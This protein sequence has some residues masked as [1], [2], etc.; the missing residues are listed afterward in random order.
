MLKLFGVTTF[1]L[2]S[3]FLT[4]CKSDVERNNEV[5][6]DAIRMSNLPFD[7]PAPDSGKID[8]QNSTYTNPVKKIPTQEE[9]IKQYKVKSITETDNSS[10]FIFNYDK[11]GNLSSTESERSGKTMYSYKFDEKGRIIQEKTKSKDGLTTVLKFEYNEDG[12][13]ISKTGYYGDD[14]KENVTRWEYDTNSNTRTEYNSSGKDKEFY[15]NRGLRV[16]FESFDEQGKFCGSCIATYN[17]DGLKM[18][19]NSKIMGMIIDDEFEYNEKGQLIQQHR[20][21][22]L[23]VDFLIEYDAKG[24][25]LSKTN[26][27]GNVEE[28]TKYEYTFY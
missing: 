28:K 7:N 1:M 4:S 24:L 14:P 9:L 16:R 20:T 22:I 13:K 26:I 2:L 8:I 23:T 27:K 6:N 21:G 5:I 10:I 11:D 12:K 19:E 17:A 25:I 15:D 18:A 3:T